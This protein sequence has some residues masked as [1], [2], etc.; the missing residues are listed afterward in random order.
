MSDRFDR[1]V[2]TCRY[3][4]NDNRIALTNQGLCLDLPS[5][6]LNN[7]QQLQVSNSLGRS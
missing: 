6:N 7:F 1:P 4:T 5:G 2:L 3:Y